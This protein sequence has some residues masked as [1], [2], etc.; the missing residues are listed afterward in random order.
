MSG[1]TFVVSQ[2]GPHVAR[3]VQSPCICPTQ[4]READ[5]VRAGHLLDAVAQRVDTAAASQQQAASTAHAW[6]LT[7]TRWRLAPLVP[8]RLPIARSRQLNLAPAKR[9]FCS[10]GEGR[11]SRQARQPLKCRGGWQR[12]G[13]STRGRCGQTGQ[14]IASEMQLPANAAQ[15]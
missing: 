12:G 1:T 10:Q 5:C 8:P 6:A 4:L 15:R 11:M 3:Y 2:D 13:Y 14:P 7:S 9:A